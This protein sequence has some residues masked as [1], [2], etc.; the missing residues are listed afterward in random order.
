[1]VNYTLAKYRGDHRKVFAVGS[2]SGAMMTNVLAA[3]YPDIFIGAAAFS[4]IP[5]ACMEGSP[6]SSPQDGDHSC[7]DGKI[8]KTGQQWADR[9][10]AAYPGYNGP[11]PKIALFHGTADTIVTYQCLIEEIKQWTTIHNVSFKKNITD[12]P[13]AGFTESVYG[14]GKKVVAFTQDGGVHFTPFQENTVLKFFGLI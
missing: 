8:Q 5:Y 6:A 11:Y 7:I 4:G 3:A 9:V 14:D 1:M 10:R 12:T 2:S 13:S